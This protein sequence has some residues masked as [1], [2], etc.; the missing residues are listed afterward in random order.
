M[1]NKWQQGKGQ[2]GFHT[3]GGS[4]H[5]PATTYPA[6]QSYGKGNYWDEWNKGNK[7]GY[8]YNA[9]TV[10]ACKPHQEWFKIGNEEENYEIWLKSSAGYIDKNV[11]IFLD[12]AAV[13]NVKTIPPDLMK[14]LPETAKV[15]RRVT[16]EITDGKIDA[17]AAHFALNM[18]RDGLKLGW[19]CIGGH[20]RTGWLAAKVHQLITGCS[21]DEAVEHVR[22]NY[23]DDAIETQ[24][25]LDDLGAKTAKPG[26]WG[27][28]VTYV[29]S[30]KTI[31]FDPP[32]G[33]TGP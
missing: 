23:C 33:V 5:K 11:D 31:G 32:G 3:G 9:T 19:G 7:T 24:I 12:L 18:L 29:N 6:T 22:K 2:A 4:G 15:V 16:Y 17:H 20:G 30:Y 13:Y 28:S 8:G 27:Y 1:S 10:A 14:Y 26:K 21:G 25:Q